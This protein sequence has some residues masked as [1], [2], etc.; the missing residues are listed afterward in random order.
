LDN[1]K[2]ENVITDKA[3]MDELLKLLE[4]LVINKI[5]IE[6][7]NQELNNKEYKK[8]LDQETLI[9]SKVQEVVKKMFF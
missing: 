8:V 4:E 6:K 9:V 5:R 7:I 1:D 2:I 3:K